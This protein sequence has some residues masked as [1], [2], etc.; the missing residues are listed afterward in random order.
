MFKEEINLNYQPEICE[1][2]CA[3][4]IKDINHHKSN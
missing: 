4:K 2:I 1:G 3:I